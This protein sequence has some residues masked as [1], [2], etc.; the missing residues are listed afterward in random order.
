[1]LAAIINHRHRI[2]PASMV[3]LMASYVRLYPLAVRLTR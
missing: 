2:V 1:M 3:F